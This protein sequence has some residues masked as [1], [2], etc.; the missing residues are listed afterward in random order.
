MKDPE[1]YPGTTYIPEV[2]EAARRAQERRLVEEGSALWARRKKE[3]LRHKHRE[4]LQLRD[5]LAQY[6]PWGK[7]GGG[8]PCA[9]TLRKK[10]VRLYSPEPMQRTYTSTKEPNTKTKLEDDV[11]CDQKAARCYRYPQNQPL[12]GSIQEKNA[13]TSRISE[14]QLQKQRYHKHP[15]HRRETVQEEMT[16]NRS[17]D[18][19]LGWTDRSPRIDRSCIDPLALTDMNKFYDHRANSGITPDP[20]PGPIPISEPKNRYNE[21]VQVYKLTGGVELVPLL[22]NN[23]YQSEPHAIRYLATDATRPGYTLE[24]LK[25]LKSLSIGN[26]E[27]VS[28]LAQQ[29]DRK[30]ERIVEEQRR[31]RENCRRHYDTWRRLWGRPGHGAPID[32]SQ[33]TNLHNILYRPTIY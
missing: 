24:S 25:A 17:H 15:E 32:H 28:Q 21:D 30:R 20:H 22:T 33:R 11:K 5:M 31:E 19:K 26:R 12:G 13:P 8:A 2:E 18:K 1:E 3:L 16:G 10:N 7:P 23:K 27:Y 9:A 14:K 29:I 4:Q 6:Y